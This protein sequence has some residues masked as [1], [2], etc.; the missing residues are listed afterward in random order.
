MSQHG[1]EGLV[2]VHLRYVRSWLQL[3]RGDVLCYYLAAMF[4][5]FQDIDTCVFEIA[6]DETGAKRQFG[7]LTTVGSGMVPRR[8]ILELTRGQYRPS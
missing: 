2:V 8:F 6:K 7:S 5:P 1:N 3:E 4:L